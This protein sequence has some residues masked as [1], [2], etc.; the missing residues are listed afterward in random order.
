MATR[1]TTL[2]SLD[3]VKHYLQVS[4]GSRD[5]E[6]DNLADAISERIE[7]HTGRVF[8]T[9]T[10]VDT[11]NGSGAVRLFLRKMPVVSLSSLTLKDT[12]DQVTPTPL[13]SGTDIDLDLKTGIVRRRSGTFTKGFQNVVATYTAGWGAQDASTLPADVVFAGL[14]WIKA[15]WDERTSNA[16]AASSISIG[17]SSM[18]L[19][20]GLPAGI[21]ATLNTW[22]VRHVA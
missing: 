6:L 13:V 21:Q 15:E 4:D 22:C 10:V 7:A 5:T 8:V 11:L 17:P 14:K 1:A 20:P 12:P 3:T 19:K 2:F 18:I 16:V 9:R